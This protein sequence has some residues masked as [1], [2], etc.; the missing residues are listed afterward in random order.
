[1]PNNFSQVGL[2]HTMLPGAIIIDARRHPM[3]SCFSTFKQYFAE[4][5]SFSYDLEE[6]GRYYRCYLQL[7]DHCR[8]GAA[9][10]G[11]SSAVRGIG[12]GA[13]DTHPP[14]AGALRVAIRNGVLVIPR[15]HTTGSNGQCEQ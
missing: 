14:A 13:G 10:E 5:Q 8:I 6:L 9:G 3:D 4:G 11:T 15:D 1:M 2:I 12:A 7:M